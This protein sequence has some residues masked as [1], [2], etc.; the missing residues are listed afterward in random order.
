MTATSKKP[1]LFAR[2][3]PELF[4][5]KLN[6]EWIIF[7]EGT[8]VYNKLEMLATE[9]DGEVGI[10]LQKKYGIH[11]SEKEQTGEIFKELEESEK[12]YFNYLQQVSQKTGVP[13][14]DIQ[15]L[16]DTNSLVVATLQDYLLES[17]TKEN[18]KKT[19]KDNETETKTQ[20]ATKTQEAIYE[21]K[22]NFKKELKES[23]T[24]IEIYLGELNELNQKMTEARDVYYR[25][26]I[27]IFLGSSYRIPK[28]AK[29]NL[30]IKFAKE[31]IDNLH[32]GF[33]QLFFADYMWQEMNGWEKPEEK[34]EEKTPQADEKKESK[35][36][37][38]ESTV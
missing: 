33:I 9:K 17:A 15:Q 25:Q 7:S 35:K 38:V 24:D 28:I 27:A 6:P 14:S 19:E 2:F 21:L 1:S 11:L 23:I 31:E 4:F 10:E 22:K 3:K 32:T 30:E 20:I 26:L 36:L 13:K 8:E 37:T 5:F 12:S 29:E 34:P 18:T 16:L